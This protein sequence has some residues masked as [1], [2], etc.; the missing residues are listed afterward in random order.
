MTGCLF[1]H[2]SC[3]SVYAL[4]DDL[5]A[6]GVDILNPIQTSAAGMDPATLKAAYGDRLVFWGGLDVQQFLP[7]ATP[8]EV[9]DEVAKLVGTLGQ[10]GGYVLAPA[11][12]I[13]GDVPPENIVAW[14]EA[15][16]G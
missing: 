4:L 5:L 14:V 12:N 15:A 13:Q 16:R 9:R 10:D 8:D 2:H 11:H 3:G 7:Q 1:W 6:C